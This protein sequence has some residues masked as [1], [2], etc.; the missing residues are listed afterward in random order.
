MAKASEGRGYPSINDK[1][2]AQ[3]HYPYVDRFT[4]NIPA[5]ETQWSLK[6]NIA[7]AFNEVRWCNYFTI[8]L[9]GAVTAE[10]VQRKNKHISSLGSVNGTFGLTKT[11]VTDI[12]FTSIGAVNANTCTMQGW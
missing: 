6:D 1:M 2:A 11:D 9:S 3:G 5:G 7:A 12:L 4:F 10:L 8:T